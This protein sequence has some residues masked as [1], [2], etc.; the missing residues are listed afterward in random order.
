MSSRASTIADLRAHISTVAPMRTGASPVATGIPNLDAHIQG[1]PCP[2]L[3]SI[4]GAVGTG[5]FGLILPS[6]Q[7]HTNDNRM[8]AIV[9]P[10]GWLYPP[11]LPGLQLEHMMLVRCGGERAAWATAQLAASGAVPLIVLLDPP[12]LGRD[13]RRMMRATEMGQSTIAVL[14]ERPDPHLCAPVRLRTLGQKQIQIER[15]ASAQP[16]ITL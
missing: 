11:G 4:H 13:A 16:V 12:P 7:A 10:L 3:V 8:V 1:W 6:L 2:G 9:D 15:G 14:T 5:R